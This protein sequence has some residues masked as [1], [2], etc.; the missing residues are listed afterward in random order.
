MGEERNREQHLQDPEHDVHD[1][2][3]SST[4]TS[5][6]TLLDRH[7]TTEMGTMT[8]SSCEL[9]LLHRNDVVDDV[10]GVPAHTSQ[11]RRAQRVEEEK[12]D[13]VETGTG[14]DDAPIVNGKAVAAGSEK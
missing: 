5:N 3:S 4:D 11:E 13:E 14:F 7:P 12:P 10:L 8:A 6:E 1:V 2:P 9:S